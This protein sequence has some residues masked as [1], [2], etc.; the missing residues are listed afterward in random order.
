MFSWFRRDKPEQRS[1]DNDGYAMLAMLARAEA[2]TDA[3][4]DLSGVVAGCTNLWANGLSMAETDCDLLTPEVLSSIGRQLADSGNSVW[5]IGP[6]GL[7]PV[8]SYSVATTDDGKPR[9]YHICVPGV[10]SGSQST[11]LADEVLHIRIGADARTPWRGVAPLRRAQVSAG[12]L[13]ATEVA[14]AEVFRDAPIGSKVLG[15]PETSAGANT[16]LAAS[17]KGKHGRVLV[18][19]SSTVY[20][21]SQGTPDDWRPADLTPNLR[22]SMAVESLKAARDS[23]LH[24]YGVLPALMNDQSAGPVI[25]EAQRHLAMWTLAPISNLIKHEVKVK[26]GEV[27][28]L[29]VFVGLGAFDAGGAARAMSTIIDGLAAAKAG[30][31]TPDELAMALKV[32]QVA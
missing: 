24:V 29:D 31:I 7:L 16:K 17:F 8:A 4:A 12:L 11:M 30:G 21:G 18:R 28:K 15:M 19:D 26:T 32:S 9:A 23:V 13:S 20:A 10:D 22:D 25:R 1:I 27:I 14:L 3:G 5:V 2:I 6:D